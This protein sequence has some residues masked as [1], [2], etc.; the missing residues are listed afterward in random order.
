MAIENYCFC[1]LAPLY[2][3]DL[4]SDSKRLWVEQQLQEFPELAEELA[5]YYT[6]ATAIPYGVPVVAMAT[7]LKDRLFALLELAPVESHQPINQNQ[8]ENVQRSLTAV[9]AQDIQWQ[10]HLVPGVE[11][12]ILHT[13]NVKREVVGILRAQKGVHYPLHRHAIGEEIY[14]LEGD[15]I[16]GSEVYGT[17]DYIRST[18]GSS[19][20]PYTKGGCMFL[21]RTSMDDEY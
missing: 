12:A 19:H 13:D 9:R 20:A 10:P 17:F 7:D 4:L 21:F 15:L 3:L 6:A 18:P 2:V 16:I 8:S 11:I 14:M 1:E 5:Y